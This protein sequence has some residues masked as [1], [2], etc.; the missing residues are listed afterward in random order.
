M[1]PET[2]G[3]GGLMLACLHARRG[4]ML[5]SLDARGG[6]TGGLTRNRRS[7]ISE[8]FCSLSSPK[9]PLRP[10][11]RTIGVVC[12]SRIRGVVGVV[13]V[14]TFVSSNKIIDSPPVFA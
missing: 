13:Y 1:T 14:K 6:T 12:I 2:V 10:F 3:G 11:S 7:C 5:V 4:S 8:S 9:V